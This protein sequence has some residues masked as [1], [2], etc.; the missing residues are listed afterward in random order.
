MKTDRRNADHFHVKI[1]VMCTFLSWQFCLFCLLS[2][3]FQ[4]MFQ[5]TIVL[6][7]DYLHIRDFVKI[8]F[9]LNL[10]FTALVFGP[11]TNKLGTVRV[12]LKHMQIA[13]EGQ[14]RGLRVLSLCVAIT[15]CFRRSK[16]PHCRQS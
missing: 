3:E 6:C 9:F 8:I 5:I 16:C 7:S 11:N 4:L 1:L 14:T 10:H 13:K 15:R 12:S 2:V